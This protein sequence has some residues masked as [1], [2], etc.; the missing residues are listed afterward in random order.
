M[1]YG[2]DERKH[3]ILGGKRFLI[4]KALAFCALSI[5]VWLIINVQN[6]QEYIA[7]YEQRDREVQD[8]EMLE[9]RIRDL[10][11]KQHSLKNNGFEKERQVRDRIGMHY[12]GEK[13]IFL[14][15]EGALKNTT[16]SAERATTAARSQRASA[17]GRE[18]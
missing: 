7:T 6:I 12:P 8:I 13:V 18:D 4:F 5:S 17:S 16:A 10:E 2:D 9:Q 1:A 3:G 15:P 14:R 11:R